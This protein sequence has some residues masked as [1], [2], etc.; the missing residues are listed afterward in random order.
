MIEDQSYLPFLS[1]LGNFFLIK[2]PRSTKAAMPSV[3]RPPLRSTLVVLRLEEPCE[4]APERLELCWD[5][6]IPDSLDAKSL[7]S[8]FEERSR[9]LASLSSWTFAKKSKSLGSTIPFFI[10]ISPLDSEIFMI[11]ESMLISSNK[12]FWTRNPWQ[13]WYEGWKS[14]LK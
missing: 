7:D 1:S 11:K 12:C 8:G 6:A 5:R 9:D 4:G 2:E 14:E 10:Y 13:N 3:T